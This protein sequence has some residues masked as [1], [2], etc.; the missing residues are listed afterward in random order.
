MKKMLVKQT[1]PGSVM[2]LA[3]RASQAIT[4][5]VTLAVVAHFLS[6]VEQGYFYTLASIAALHMA[7]DM[8][9]SSI[10]IQF[11][12]REFIGLNFGEIGAVEGH[13]PHRFLALVRQSIR[14]YC[15]TA[16]MFLLIYPVG[17]FYLGYS[18]DSLSFD[19][20][21]PWSALVCATAAG[22]VFLPALAL[23][24]GC[25][26]VAEV[27]AVR[28][29]QGVVGGLVAWGTLALDGG[30][31]AVAVPAAVSAVVAAC[32]VFWRRRGMI[33]QALHCQASSF[34][35]VHEV[36]PLQWRIGASWL[37]GYAMVL[38][39]VPL[40]FRTQGPVVAGQMGVCMTV[41]NMLSLLALSWVTAR[42]PSMATAVSKRDWM[43]LDLIYWLAFK[44]SCLTFLA[45]AVAFLVL[46]MGLDLTPYGD[47]FL[48]VAQCTGLLVAMGFYHL[49]GLFA[50]YLRAHL[51]EPFFWP[52]L[53]GALLTAASAVWVAPQWGSAGVVTVLIVINALFFFPAALFL[54]FYLRRKWHVESS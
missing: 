4:G 8:G 10:L 2:V 26:N 33:V 37:A 53:V 48:S 31:Y 1:D 25:G 42:I 29:A 51:K 16:V 7:L 27:Y 36:W 6:P 44:A 13:S 50:A 35:W 32:W 24:E 54:W 38:M 41:A 14:W 5:V 17:V 12:A 46:R 20:R 39:H 3:H 52:S 9:L 22:F 19:W 28:L 34:H 11:A 45:G 21:G 18:Q 30:L 15:F 43:R 47:R 23:T 49:S 40:L